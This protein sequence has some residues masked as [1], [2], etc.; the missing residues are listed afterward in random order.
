MF[1]KA[2]ASDSTADMAEWSKALGLRPT[3]LK[4]AWVR[5]PLSAFLFTN[6]TRKRLPHASFTF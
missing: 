4:S 3:G 2:I 6:H 1:I 5:T